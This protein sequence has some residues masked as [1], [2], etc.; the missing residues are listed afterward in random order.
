QSKEQQCLQR[1]HW[2]MAS[3]SSND[4]EITS[5]FSSISGEYRWVHQMEEK[6]KK[7]LK[8]DIKC[9]LPCISRVPETLRAEKPEA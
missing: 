5:I 2:I 4:T 8:I 6:F 3:E 7:E 9:D 1:R